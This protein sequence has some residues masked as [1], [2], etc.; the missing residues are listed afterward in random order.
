ML[1][2][3]QKN[4]GLP[5]NSAG[6]VKIGIVRSL[7]NSEMTENLERF[8]R[9]TLV[10]NGVIDKNILTV[11]VPGSLEIPIAAQ[12]LAKT[13][14]YDCLIALGV[15]LKGETFHFELVVNE[16]VRGCMQV[17]LLHNIPVICEILAAYTLEQARARTGNDEFNKGIEAANSALHIVET[18]KG[19]KNN[20]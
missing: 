12:A 15:V 7:F 3:S 20:D 17:A 8:C 6:K 4:N 14:K 2:K 9:E 5:K 16:S 10:L 11:N 13:K 19:I 1:K 18:L